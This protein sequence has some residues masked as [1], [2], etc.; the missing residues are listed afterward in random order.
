M[1]KGFTLVELLAAIVI[2][3]IILIIA[4][5]KITDIITNSRKDAFLSS[6]KAILR[7]LDYQNLENVTLA[8]TSL[9]SLNITSLSSEDYDLNTSTVYMNDGQLY[10]N[11]VGKGKFEGYYTCDLS[12]TSNRFSVTTEGCTMIQK[13]KNVRYIKDCMNGSNSNEYSHWVEIEAISNVTNVALGK[14]VTGSTPSGATPYSIITDGD[15]N[16][17]VL[18]E[19]SV[20]NILQCV[21]VDLSSNYDLDKI[22]VWHYW[23]DGRIYYSNTTYVSPDNLNWIPV[24]SKDEAETSVGKIVNKTDKNSTIVPIFRITNILNNGSFEDGMTGYS[25][26]GLD[27]TSHSNGGVDNNPYISVK[28]TN[29]WQNLSIGLTL[30]I[31]HK[32][33]VSRYIKKPLTTYNMPFELTNYEVWSNVPA[34]TELLDTWSKNS[35]LFDSTGRTSTSYNLFSYISGG[36]SSA[37]STDTLDLSSLIV[38]DLTK[39]FGVGKEPSKEWCDQNINYFRNSVSNR[40]SL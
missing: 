18:A 25:Y 13:L 12:K 6:A 38:V 5:P 3:S 26:G 9:S 8:E 35:I 29:T 14:T 24:I 16:L 33:Y 20:N 10:L 11:L 21:T 40:F 17:S 32:Y 37:L 39:T 23:G 22:T 2:L 27:L 1:K 34:G 4:I 31:N 19:P 15:H 36:D 30:P 7:G 28:A